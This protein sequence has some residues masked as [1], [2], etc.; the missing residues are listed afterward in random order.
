MRMTHT[1]F[2]CDICGCTADNRDQLPATPHRGEVRIT[3]AIA[4]PQVMPAGW[5][6]R[7]SH[8]LCPRCE[9]GALFLTDLDRVLRKG[10]PR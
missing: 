8:D 4:F 3:M 7:A 6:R 2:T 5:V 1:V 10:G 9:Q